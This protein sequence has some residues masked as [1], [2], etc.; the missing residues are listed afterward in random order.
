MRR[1]GCTCRHG[2]T[3][4]GQFIDVWQQK[5]QALQASTISKV[6]LANASHQGSYDIYWGYTVLME[7]TQSEPPSMRLSSELVSGLSGDIFLTPARALKLAL[8]GT[9]DDDTRDSLEKSHVA[10][11]VRFQAFSIPRI[12]RVFWQNLMLTVNELLVSSVHA[13]LIAR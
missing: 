9:M 4:N 13:T 12:N 11:K 10:S 3:E 2:L 7:S 6:I 1:E 8:K 5:Q